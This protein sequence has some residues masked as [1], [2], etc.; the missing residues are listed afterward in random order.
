MFLSTKLARALQRVAG[1]LDSRLA[2]TITPNDNDEIESDGV[3]CG[4]GP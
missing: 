1:M 4:I 2:L 3:R